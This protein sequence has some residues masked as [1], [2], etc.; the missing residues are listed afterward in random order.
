VFFFVIREAPRFIISYRRRVSSRKDV[1]LFTR[2]GNDWS[3]PAP[4]RRRGRDIPQSHRP[5]CRSRD[6]NPSSALA[7]AVT[8][9]SGEIVRLG[10]NSGEQPRLLVARG[11]NSQGCLFSCDNK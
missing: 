9:P 3:E 7:E 1:R 10:T 5:T 8:L 4:R 6:G 11:P 2:N